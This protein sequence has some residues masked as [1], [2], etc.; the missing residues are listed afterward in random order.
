MMMHGGGSD[1]DDE[2]EVNLV[3][4]S[5]AF[6]SSGPT[7]YLVLFPYNPDQSC[8]VKQREKIR[9]SMKNLTQ[10]ATRKLYVF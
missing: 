2:A 7:L 8:H 3:N 6:A 4:F 9:Y 5:P 1:N 10:P